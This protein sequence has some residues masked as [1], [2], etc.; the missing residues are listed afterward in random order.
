MK[1]VIMNASGRFPCAVR[2]TIEEAGD[3][4]RRLAIE[5]VGDLISPS[6]DSWLI[7]AVPD[8]KESK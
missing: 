8:E 4:V 3:V 1:Y 7:V 5:N 2:D 6:H